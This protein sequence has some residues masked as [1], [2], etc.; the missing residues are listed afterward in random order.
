[1]SAY[2]FDPNEDPNDVAGPLPGFD[3]GAELERT[4]PQTE[5][6]NA[7]DPNAAAAAIPGNAAV[8]PGQAEA[9]PIGSD[10]LAAPDLGPASAMMGATAPAPAPAL[11]DELAA[12]ADL[13]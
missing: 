7:F 2:G 13:A 11:G 5:A 9:G 3:P 4:S 12:P 8:T 1:M 10:A 6:L